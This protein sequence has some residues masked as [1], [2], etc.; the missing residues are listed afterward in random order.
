MTGHQQLALD[1]IHRCIIWSSSSIA[2]AD[3]AYIGHMMLLVWPEM[4]CASISSSNMACMYAAPGA[5]MLTCMLT[6]RAG[7]AAQ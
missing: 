2:C 1:S 7:L 4:A 6:L 5:A 3:G